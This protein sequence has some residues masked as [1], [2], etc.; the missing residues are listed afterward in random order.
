MPYADIQ[1]TNLYY[2]SQGRG[3]PLILLHNGLGCTKSFTKQLPEFSRYFRVI[4]Y[5][6]YGYGRST[7]MTSLKTGWLEQSVDELSHFL[8]RMHFDRANLCGICV[9]GAIALLFAARNPSR[10]DRVVAAG[11]CCFGD[12]EISRR[13]LKLYPHPTHLSPDWLH[14]LTHHHGKTYGRKL[15]EIFYQAIQEE[16]GYPF[17]EYDLRPTLH[18]VRNPVLVIHGERDSLFKLDQA[19]TMQKCLDKTGLCIIPDCGHLPNEEKLAEFNQQT[20]KFLRR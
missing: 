1:G 3:E 20:L 2:E 5:D 16:N 7:H 12:E 13:A 19:L 10:V 9:G 6:R 18:H 17:K 8:D 15:Y 11:T 14:D 4:A